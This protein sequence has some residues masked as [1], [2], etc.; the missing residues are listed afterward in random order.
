MKLADLARNILNED[1][2]ITT[3]GAAPST[4]GTTG[5]NFY[6]VLKDFQEFETTLDKQTETAKKALESSL[7]KNLLNKQVTLRASKGAVGQIEK[8]YTITVTGVGVFMLK[9]EYFVVLK[10]KEKKDYYVNTAFKIKVSDAAPESDDSK[11]ADAPQAS[12]VTKPEV[13]LKNTGP[14]KYPQNMG[15][16]GHKV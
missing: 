16:A 3:P 14:I 1:G 5:E 9:D 2:P 13:G 15:I 4:A 8:D 12:S 10:D 11:V 7:S 6:D